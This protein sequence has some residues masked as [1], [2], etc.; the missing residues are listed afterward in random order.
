M[1]KLEHLPNRIFLFKKDVR[2]MQNLD[3]DL[4]YIANGNVEYY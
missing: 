4:T 1:N 3:Q 2:K